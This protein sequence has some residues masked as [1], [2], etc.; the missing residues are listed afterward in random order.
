MLNGA[1]RVF[2]IVAIAAMVLGC[3]GDK[4]TAANGESTADQTAASSDPVKIENKDAPAQEE[5]AKEPDMAATPASGEFTDQTAPDKF[6]VVLE[7]TKGDIVIDVERAW[8]PKGA[9]RFYSLVK[10]GYYTDVAFF[11]VIEGFMAQVGIHGEPAMNTIWRQRRIQDDPKGVKSNTRGL[12]SFATAGPNTRTVQFFINFGDNNRLDGMGFTPFG[13]VRD[14]KPVDALY[15]GYGEGA[16]RGKGPF[17]GRL[18]QEGNPYLK[19]EFPEMD[20][21]KKARI[22]A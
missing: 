12:V 18:Q 21:I 1:V 3:G 16:P 13:K 19:K 20:Y 9:D 17:Q 5:D 4:K 11:R 2:A 22:E 6:A 8:A 15:S 14:M 10:A 7:T